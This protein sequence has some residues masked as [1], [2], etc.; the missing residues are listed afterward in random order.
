MDL[1]RRPKPFLAIAHI[2]F[3]PFVPFIIEL[4]LKL[5]KIPYIIDIDDSVYIRYKNKNKILQFF[6]Y[7]KFKYSLQ[8]ASRIFVGNNFHYKNLKVYNK[9]IE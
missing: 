4:I 2:E 7:L 1:T 5:R 6:D 9:N 3:L 8:N